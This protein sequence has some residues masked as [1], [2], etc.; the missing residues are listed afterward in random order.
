MGQ[1]DEAAQQFR[2]IVSF[3][4]S[5]VD[6]YYNLGDL[7]LQ[8]NKVSEA[9][10][11]YQQA[12]Q[13]KPNDAVTYFNLSQAYA[14]LNQSEAAESHAQRGIALA[15]ESGDEPLVKQ[16]SEWLANYQAQR[17]NGGGNGPQSSPQH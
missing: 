4:P 14:Y 16:V 7:L 3:D 8:S 13:L 12:L 5:Y 17:S 10:P 9:V 6:A 2:Q 15:K 1:N 11:V